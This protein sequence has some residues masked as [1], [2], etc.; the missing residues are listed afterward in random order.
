MTMFGAYPA[1]EVVLVVRQVCFLPSP[2]F[3]WK[4]REVG[5]VMNDGWEVEAAS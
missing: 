1:E 5:E 2:V 3:F 4:G